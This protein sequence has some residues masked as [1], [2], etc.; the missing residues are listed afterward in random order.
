MILKKLIFILMVMAHVSVSQ[1]APVFKKPDV[2]G[3]VV[4]LESYRGRKNV[5]LVFSRYIGCS[6][7]QMFIIDLIGKAEAIAKTD[8]EVII[9][10]NSNERVAK[11]YKPPRDFPFIIVPDP[12][13]G[14]YKQYGVKM[15]GKLFTWNVFKK[16]LIFVKY[17][18]KYRWVKGGLKGEHYQPPAC[19]VID[20]FLI[21]RYAHVGKDLADNPNAANILKILAALNKAP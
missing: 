10:T 20:K 9:I 19:F 18:P 5:L 8:T 21:V 17:L 7:C 6:W 2:K 13:M 1:P 14:I 3:K 4:D 16:S 12:K 15:K 11:R